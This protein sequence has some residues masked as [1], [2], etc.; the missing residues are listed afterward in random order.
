[1]QSNIEAGDFASGQVRRAVNFLS[2]RVDLTASLRINC[3]CHFDDEVFLDSTGCLGTSQMPSAVKWQSQGKGVGQVYFYWVNCSYRDVNEV[4]KA[5]AIEKSL[6]LK[7][8]S[9]G[10]RHNTLKL[11]L[12]RGIDLMFLKD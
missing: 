8:S 1:V 6:I 2:L 3:R 4:W 7:F 5:K 12:N 9:K 11:Y 10:Q